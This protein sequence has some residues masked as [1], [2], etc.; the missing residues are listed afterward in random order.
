MDTHYDI[1]PLEEV[2][3][4]Q[5]EARARPQPVLV[6]AARQ[7]AGR[8]RS[9]RLWWNA[10]RALAASFRWTPL[11]PVET[12]SQITLVAGLAAHGV[13]DCSLKWPNDLVMG[14]R[15]VGGILTETDGSSVV[16]G[17]G[18]NLWWPEPPER[19]GAVFE[20]DPGPDAALG[21]AT[22]WVDEL[23]RRLDEGPER[24][25]IDEYRATCTTIGKAVTWSPG[26]AGRA[27]GV[28]ELGR[29]VVSV[30][31]SLV[32]LSS[33]EVHLVSES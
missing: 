24:W 28:D 14:G 13:F 29:L 22:R 7:S 12:W 31:G 26:G 4:T 27:V 8:G 23:L 9:G 18:V 10:P 19:S 21:L 6:V 3:S 30:G 15:K 32:A 1:I 33:G 25:G 17:L 2:T 20:S 11:W 16:C 5:D